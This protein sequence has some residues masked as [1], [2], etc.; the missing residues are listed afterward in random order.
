MSIMSMR[1]G[2]LLIM[3]VLVLGSAPATAQHYYSGPG[4]AGVFMKPKP[5]ES[6]KKA[7]AK[8]RHR[9]RAVAHPTLP[10][11][12]PKST[13]G[14]APATE[15]IA[16]K[17]TPTKPAQKKTHDVGLPVPR[18]DLNT[19]E[20]GVAGIPAGERMTIQ[21]ALLWAGDYAGVGESD[22]PLSAAVKNYQKRHKA[23]I[24]GVLTV[25]ERAELLAAGDRYRRRYGWRVVTDPATG[26]RIGLP[27]KLAPNVQDAAH[28]T[29]WSSPHGEVQI[30]TF[31]LRQ[32]DLTIKDLYAR[33]R[34]TP[35]TRRVSR[36]TL[37]DDD[38][39]LHGMQGLKYF[40][41]RAVKRDG[42]IRGFTLLYDQAMLGIVAPVANAMASAF[43]PF[44]ARNMPFAM[45]AKPVEYGTGLIVS[46]RG[47]I[48]TDR[49]ITDGCKVI[50]AAG[51]GNAERVAEDKAQG[52]ALLR[53]Y[54]QSKL[55]PLPLP[56]EAASGKTLTLVGIPD[57]KAQHG[58]LTPQEIKARLVGDAA[59]NLQR[60][61][62]LA[63]LSGAAVLGQDGQ[64]HAQVLGMM[65]T[66]KAVLAS[67]GPLLA[68]VHLVR[69]AAIRAFLKAHDVTPAREGNTRAALVRVICVRK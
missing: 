69:A 4:D 51:L 10:Q 25:K 33:E 47:D 65:E 61:V 11:P 56:A 64:G 22:D 59:I 38:F 42:E 36:S 40:D 49:Q 34:K 46:A 58:A 68:P 17:A 19:P 8:H 39:V 28:G 32:P 2:S 26:I 6:D 60:P 43:A 23:K 13:T 7:A 12:A 21:S 9:R 44:L 54:G 45:L 48:V 3:L 67:N 29:R 50:V 24:T 14:K 62:P 55:T 66:R 30:E 37:H 57:P 52:L 18:P 41:V 27:A 16:A 20:S 1:C 5:A 53:V 63:G 31:R 35:S 15:S